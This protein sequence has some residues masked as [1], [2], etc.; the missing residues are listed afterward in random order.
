MQATVAVDAAVEAAAAATAS[1][2]VSGCSDWSG[3][4]VIPLMMSYLVIYALYENIDS[5]ELYG[6][7]RHRSIKGHKPMTAKMIISRMDQRHP[8]IPIVLHNKN[9]RTE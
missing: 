9:M 4:S 1:L 3:D 2:H 5:R 6:G 7:R 8:Q